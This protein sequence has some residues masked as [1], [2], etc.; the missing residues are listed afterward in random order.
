MP[1]THNGFSC[2]RSKC[3]QAQ[4]DWTNAIPIF[5]SIVVKGKLP[6]ATIVSVAAEKNVDFPTFAL[7][8]NP[9]CNTHKNL[10]LLISIAEIV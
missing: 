4:S 8:I 6:E 1:L 3:L 9:I 5:G 2:L 7:P 10:I